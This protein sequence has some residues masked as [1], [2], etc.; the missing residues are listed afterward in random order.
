[1]ATTAAAPFLSCWPKQA[2]KQAGHEPQV[3]AAAR[4]I[5]NQ[6]FE[7]QLVAR[8]RSANRSLARSLVRVGGQWH[9]SCLLLLLILFR[10][11][12]QIRPEWCARQPGDLLDVR[13]CVRARPTHLRS[14][15]FAVAA[16]AD[17]AAARG[18]A[19]S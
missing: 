15:M 18:P 3:A 17:A 16:A 1:M 9:L 4:I 5:E 7:P 8:A 6:T 13:Y 10:W 14:P 12:Y 19:A 11:K 2:S